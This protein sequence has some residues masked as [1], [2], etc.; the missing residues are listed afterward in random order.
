[1]VY[2]QEVVAYWY[3][4]LLFKMGHYFLD[5]RYN[6]EY[7]ALTK[8][9]PSFQF[10]SDLGLFYTGSYIFISSMKGNLRVFNIFPEFSLNRGEIRWN[11]NEENILI[12]GDGEYIF[13]YIYAL[14]FY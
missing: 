9:N 3:S 11:Y 10:P 1:M 4:N 2:V 14:G 5:R 6:I 13:F 8:R 12:E 7:S